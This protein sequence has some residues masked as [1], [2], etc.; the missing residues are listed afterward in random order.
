MTIMHPAML[1]FG[2]ALFSTVR[3]SLNY[4]SYLKSGAEV[5][6]QTKE[7]TMKSRELFETFKAGLSDIPHS[8]TQNP[9]LDGTVDTVLNKVYNCLVEK[10]L[11]TIDDFLK[12]VS[13]LD[14]VA[15][16][17]GT[18]AKLLLRDKLKAT[19]AD[20]LMYLK[21]SCVHTIPFVYD[22]TP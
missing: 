13:L 22:I 7:H 3:S 8:S 21:F 14:N 4:S 16:G 6:K 9:R 18:N 17:K 11:H 12:N 2:R 5:F 1:N 10:M 15:T 20:N 19:A